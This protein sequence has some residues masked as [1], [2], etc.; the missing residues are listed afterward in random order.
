M[1]ATAPPVL[2]ILA[3]PAGSG[4]STLCDRLVAEYP[5]FSRVI[6]TTTRAPRE[7]EINGRH[8]HF[9]TLA[10]FDAKIARGEFLE[11]A[12]VHAETGDR[13]RRYGTLASSVLEPL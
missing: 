3:G 9:L 7:G 8:Y 1:S 13:N 5:T 6:T 2:L 12:V 10:E 4:K 11:W